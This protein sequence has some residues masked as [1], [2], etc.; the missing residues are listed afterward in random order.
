LWFDE[1]E[2]L[3]TSDATRL[4]FLLDLGMSLSDAL[5]RYSEVCLHHGTARD[6]AQELIEETT[7]IPENLRY[8]IDYKAI[9]RDMCI[10]GDI[11]KIEHDLIITNANEF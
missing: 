5:S 7:E 8:Y 2:D 9:A 3:T 1:L 10:N 6:Y 4:C 11:V